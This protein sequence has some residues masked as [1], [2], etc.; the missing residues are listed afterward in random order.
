MHSNVVFGVALLLLSGYNQYLCR[1]AVRLC[2][3]YVPVLTL[4]QVFADVTSGLRAWCHE[5]GLG[6]GRLDQMLL[7][8]AVGASIA[9]DALLQASVNSD[10]SF[11]FLMTR[12][13]CSSCCFNNTVAVR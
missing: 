2:V 7:D 1:N 4:G 5:V 10:V 12:Q 8:D 3:F 13:C 11:F 9:P 6:V